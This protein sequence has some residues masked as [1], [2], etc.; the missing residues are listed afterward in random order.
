MMRN[1]S[2]FGRPFLALVLVAAVA[3]GLIV[4]VGAKPTKTAFPG[5]NGKITFA[6][7]RTSGA[8]VNNPEG[9]AEIFTMNPDGTGIEQITDNDANDYDPAWSAQGD[10]IAFVSQRDNQNEEIYVMDA[11]GTDQMRLTTNA[12]SDIN[13]AFS[14]DG[15]TIAFVSSRTASGV[16]IFVMDA[17]DSDADGNGDNL[18]RLTDAKHDSSPAWSPDGTKIAFRSGRDDVQGEIYVMDAAREGVGNVPVRLTT[19]AAADFE[20]NWSP[21]GS[22]IA[23]T[24]NRDGNYEIYVMNA[25]GAAP[26]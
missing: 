21:D 10:A 5:T 14:P 16:A 9:D 24:S 22:K 19:D 6:S 2:R 12:A 1:M 13:P 17:A 23:F 15:S 7:V 25:D 3:A 18:T 20:P 26:K 4:S 11:D 8:G